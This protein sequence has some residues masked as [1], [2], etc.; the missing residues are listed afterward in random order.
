MHEQSYIEHILHT[1]GK[2]SMPLDSAEWNVGIL[3]KPAVDALRL[4]IG[5]RVVRSG[6]ILVLANRAMSERHKNLQT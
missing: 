3:Y 1:E 4:A 2:Y 6:H 5:L